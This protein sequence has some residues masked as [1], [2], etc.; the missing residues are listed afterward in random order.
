MAGG[1]KTKRWGLAL[2]GLALF[3][4]G[5]AANKSGAFKGFTDSL[6]SLKPAVK[7]VADKFIPNL[8]NLITGDRPVTDYLP[9]AASVEE[10]FASLYG[11]TPA[12]QEARAQGMASWLGGLLMNPI[13]WVVAAVGLFVLLRRR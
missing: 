1:K 13:T 2:G 11:S 4:A 6:A 8:G 3:G 9:N 12:G 10:A 7:S 5:A